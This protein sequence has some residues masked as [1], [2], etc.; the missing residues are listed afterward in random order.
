VLRKAL[1]AHLPVVLCI[2]KVD[3]P[4]ARIEEVEDEVMELLMDLIEDSEGKDHYLDLPTVYAS[5]KAGRASLNRP[6][7][8]GLPDADN[9]EPS[10]TIIEH[11]PAPTYEEGAPLQAHVTNLDASNFLGRLALLRVHNGRSARAS[12]WPGAATTARSPR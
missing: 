11:I 12:R 5:A 10:S 2:N 6:A 3:R 4:D 9:L 8:G 7:D 1:A